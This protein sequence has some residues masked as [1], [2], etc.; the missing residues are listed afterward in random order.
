MYAHMHA[1][2]LRYYSSEV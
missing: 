2:G 1:R